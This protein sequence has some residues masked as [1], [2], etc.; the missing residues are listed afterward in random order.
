MQ[1]TDASTIDFVTVEDSPTKVGLIF[2]PRHTI[3]LALQNLEGDQHC[4]VVDLIHADPNNQGK[5]TSE[6]TW[7][8]YLK[9][10]DGFD[11]KKAWRKV[12]AVTNKSR[13]EQQLIL[14]ITSIA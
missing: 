10:H 3:E 8:V 4:G 11:G 2:P 7:S 9:W 6:I 12:L 5:G 14:F 1:M 13:S